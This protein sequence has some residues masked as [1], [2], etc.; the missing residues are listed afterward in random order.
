M[1]QFGLRLSHC[2]RHVPSLER[3]LEAADL[4]RWPCP[5]RGVLLA[6]LP[7][8]GD[9]LGAAYGGSRP[10]GPAAAGEQPLLDP[11]GMPERRAGQMTLTFYLL[12]LQLVA[13]QKRLPSLKVIRFA[14]IQLPSTAF[15]I[16]SLL[17]IISSH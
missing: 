7:G 17:H 4:M 5:A 8:W 9:A 1:L 12:D 6:R 2:G 15:R 3:C 11:F 13:C 14:I 10:G 16:R